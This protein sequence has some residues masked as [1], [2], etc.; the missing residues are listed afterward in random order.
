MQKWFGLHIVLALIQ[1]C[2]GP[3]VIFV[4]LNQER[5]LYVMHLNM[6]PKVNLGKK[7]THQNTITLKTVLC[8]LFLC[9]VLLV[10][11]EH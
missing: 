11:Y 9:N 2:T 4:T 7:K 1:V 10:Q 5:F 6:F 3:Q 8:K